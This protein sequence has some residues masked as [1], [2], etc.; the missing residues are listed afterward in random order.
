MKT[1]V[2]NTRSRSRRRE[3]ADTSLGMES[4]LQ[5]AAR[6]CAGGRGSLTRLTLLTPLAT[7][8]YR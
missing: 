4:Q 3:E 2:Q 8:T 6:S 1:M 7:L 5:P